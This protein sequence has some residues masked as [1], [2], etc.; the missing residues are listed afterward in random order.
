MRRG[1]GARK[2]N[3]LFKKNP[4]RYES[5]RE[6]TREKKHSHQMIFS[7]FFSHMFLYVPNVLG[8]ERMA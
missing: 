6:G 7:F 3:K 4:T 2:H 5:K 8:T 1:E